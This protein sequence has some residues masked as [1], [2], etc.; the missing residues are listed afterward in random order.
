MWR[1]TLVMQPHNE[2]PDAPEASAASSVL[3]SRL[4]T[5]KVWGVQAL[6]LA[7]ADTLSARLGAV[8][9]EGELSAFTRAASGHCYFTLKDRSGTAALKCAMF[10]RASSMLAFAPRDGLQV[11]LR[12][13]LSV[14]EARGELQLVAES[15]ALAGE[16]AL[17]ERFLRLKANLESQ[18]LFDPSRRRALPRWVSSVG[19]VTSLAA[20]A[21]HD[22]L[23]ALARRAPHARV[24]VYPS[25]VQGADAPALLVDALRVAAARAEVDVVLL[26]RGG[27]SLEDLW[28]FND[29]RVVRAVA[30]SPIPVVSGVG[31]ESD[32]TLV[33]LAADLR[34]ATPTAAAELAVPARDALRETL[35]A[36]ARRAMQLASRRIEQH[37]LRLDRAA[38]RTHRPT[39]LLDAQRQRV[40]HLEAR[41]LPALHATL[42][43][44]KHHIDHQRT[45]VLQAGQRRLALAQQRLHRHQA[46]VDALDPSRVLARG[47]A[48]LLDADGAAVVSAAALSG[49]DAVQAVLADGRVL[50]RVE[51]VLL[52][53]ASGGAN[54]QAPTTR[55]RRAAST[56]VRAP[57]RPSTAAQPLPNERKKTDTSQG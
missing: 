38:M 30:A 36:Y 57:R 56:K 44:R 43:T 33:D 45:C 42:T 29:E 41:L 2:A 53:Q 27:G 22:V 8:A 9:I 14:Y 49:G 51:N 1:A 10:R 55:T 31:H 47:Y 15:M 21:L 5:P 50:A 7:V 12:G 18:G 23:T 20:A 16:G 24:V 3:P 35:S 34:A 39:R 26:V 37:A 52:G 6:L 32:V 46:Q 54:N 4:V 25:S 13:R 48:W 40:G 11:V 17:Y 19:V 28:A